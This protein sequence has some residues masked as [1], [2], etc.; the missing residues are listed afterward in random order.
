VGCRVGAEP[1]GLDTPHVA[2]AG[3]KWFHH[4]ASPSL[5]ARIPRLGEG[6]PAL[7]SGKPKSWIRHLSY[8]STDLF[9]TKKVSAYA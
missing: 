9:W 8:V 1:L 4:S 2:R 5:S 3:P 7:F 6:T